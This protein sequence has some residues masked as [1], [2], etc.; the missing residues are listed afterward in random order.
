MTFV[1]G[2]CSDNFT[3]GGCRNAG[4]PGDGGGGS[5]ATTKN[6]LCSDRTR[7]LAFA[8]ADMLQ[9]CFFPLFFLVWR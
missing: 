8:T 7:P 9:S 4:E 5:F 1:G 6:Q 2:T 3:F